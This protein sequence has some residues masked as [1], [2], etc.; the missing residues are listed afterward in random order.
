MPLEKLGAG[1]LPLLEQVLRHF[2][3]PLAG[4]ARALCLERATALL[5]RA[6]EWNARIDLTS[7][8]QA[9]ELVDLLF[10]DAA[11]VAGSRTVKT[12]SRWVDVGSGIGAP[13]LPLALLVP[14]LDV[15][16]VEPRTKRVSFLR[17]VIGAL[18][19][20]GVRVERARSDVLDAHSFDVAISRA[21]MPPAEW[22]VEGARL[23]RRRV[24]VLLAR[25][26]SPT[27][28]GWTSGPNL[29]FFW[30]LTQKERRACAY[31][32]EWAGHFSSEIET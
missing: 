16:L 23:A 3:V 25:A 31:D 19:L 18:G 14:G 17:T 6:V 15:T 32:R 1:F 7:V 27:L 10:A 4:E 24:W 2:D 22:L 13:G 29:S 11:A 26:A 5:D 21:T 20:E 8:T 28:D 30:P 9:E 12:G